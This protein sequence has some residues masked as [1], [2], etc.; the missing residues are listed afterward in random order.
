MTGASHT[1]TAT[2]IHPA[3]RRAPAGRRQRGISLFGLL[4]W[5]VIL[6]FLAVVGMRVAPT[7]MEYF[8]ILKAVEKIASSGPSSVSDARAAFARTQEIEY[9]IVSI[10]PNDLVITKREEKVKISFA[11]DK[12]VSLGGPVYLLIK[13][14]GETR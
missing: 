11:Y 14:K 9:S 13:Y 8:T 3:P 6:A 1:T 12:E 4:F 10:K 2:D 7:V 5:G